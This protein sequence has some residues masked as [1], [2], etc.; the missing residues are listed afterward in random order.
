MAQKRCQISS[1][2][3]GHPLTSPETCF[4]TSLSSQ[5]MGQTKPITFHHFRDVGSWM[6]GMNCQHLKMNFEFWPWF[7]L[8][9]KIFGYPMFTQSFKKIE[10]KVAVIQPIESRK[11]SQNHACSFSQL[12]CDLVLQFEFYG[13]Q[14]KDNCEPK[15]SY[16]LKVNN[17]SEFM[18][19]RQQCSFMKNE[20]LKFNFKTK[21]SVRKELI[22]HTPAVCFHTTITVFAWQLANRPGEYM[23]HPVYSS[24]GK[25]KQ[26]RQ[27]TAKK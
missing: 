12:S 8:W 3:H 21:P 7:F 23:G 10:G 14:W 25:L 2:S 20:L 18:N 11:K 4:Y 26:I 27:Y 24:G 15:K 17:I 6:S 9:G 16:L 1:W 13:A 19:E 22:Q 5:G